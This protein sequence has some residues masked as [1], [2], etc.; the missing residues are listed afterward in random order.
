MELSKI[1][2]IEKTLQNYDAEKS[3]YSYTIEYVSMDSNTMHSWTGS[4]RISGADKFNES[5]DKLVEL[6]SC[7]SIHIKVYTGKTGNKVI[8]SE[9]ILIRGKELYPMQTIMPEVKSKEKETILQTPQ[10]Q[11]QP[12][13][14]SLEFI[15]AILGVG[16]LNGVENPTQML[17]SLLT[18]RDQQLDNKYAFMQMQKDIAQ[19]QLEKKNLEEK[20]SQ[21]EAELEG[22]ENENGE[23]QDKIDELEAEIVRL[24]KY[25]PENSALGLSLTALLGSVGQR[26]INNYVTKNPAG[27]AK[28]LG[29]DSQTLLGIFN[30]NN[31]ANQQA[32]VNSP[33]V[34]IETVE[35]LS[36]QR[37]QELQAIENMAT[38]L[39]SVSLDDLTMIQQLFILFSQDN[40]LIQLVYGWAS[41]N[42]KNVSEVNLEN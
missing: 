16:G 12:Q 5:V 22:A 24:Q 15:S 41:G 1:R 34:E 33:D 10:S 39:K 27:V 37:K 38:W 26:V 35:E 20:L 9:D 30:N 36:T 7:K 8:L 25:I 17:G 21:S 29:T 14:N 42:K 32:V 3:P 31:D 11:P 4:K 40:E 28:L 18:F 2:T 23:L 6:P 13:N 19:L